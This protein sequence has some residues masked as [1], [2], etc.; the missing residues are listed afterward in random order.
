M[1]IYELSGFF[2]ESKHFYGFLL[3]CC[4]EWTRQSC[5]LD[6]RPRCSYCRLSNCFKNFFFFFAFCV[7][8]QTSLATVIFDNKPTNQCN[9]L[10]KSKRP[11]MVIGGSNSIQK[12]T[13]AANTQSWYSYCL[14]TGVRSQCVMIGKAS[15]A[16]QLL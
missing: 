8:I 5:Q 16:G 10:V 15:V 12:L 13:N 7:H 1:Y 2:L 6:G 11:F 4:S 9:V 14:A 3:H